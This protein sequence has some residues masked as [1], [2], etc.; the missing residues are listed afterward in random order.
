MTKEST[1]EKLKKCSSTVLLPTMKFSKV[2]MLIFP[3]KFTRKSRFTER[4]LFLFFVLLT[5]KKLFHSSKSLN[6]AGWKPSKIKIWFFLK[7]NILHPYRAMFCTYKLWSD[8]IF[9]N[10]EE[11]QARP[12]QWKFHSYLT[13]NLIN[14]FDFSIF[15]VVLAK[16]T[17]TRSD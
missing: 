14:Y 4:R 3:G 13:I 5:E 8:F 16:Y 11:N 10:L 15:N 7:P 12:S 9:C 6:Q 2:L 1:F 17:N